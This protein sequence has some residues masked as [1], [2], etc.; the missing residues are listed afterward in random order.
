[1]RLPAIL[2][3]GALLAG[4]GGSPAE[5]AKRKRKP[6]KPADP[7]TSRLGHSCQTKAECGHSLQVCLKQNDANG[8][9]IARGFCVLPCRAIDAG[10]KNPLPEQK[11]A[12]GGVVLQKVPARCPKKYECRSAGAGVPIDMCV[13]Q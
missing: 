8:K 4:L 5:A 3:L 9:A 12:D 7:T 10:L 1:M 6:R 13:R 2:A 11:T